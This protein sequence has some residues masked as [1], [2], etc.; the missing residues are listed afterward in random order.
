VLSQR[1]FTS[2]SAA[3][4]QYR[5]SL[6]RRDATDPW[7]ASSSQVTVAYARGA[8][9]TLEPIGIDRVLISTQHEPGLDGGGQIILF[10]N[11]RW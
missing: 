7:G 2:D 1:Y 5:A 8:D 10:L 4:Q 9:G 11:L 3:R 6:L